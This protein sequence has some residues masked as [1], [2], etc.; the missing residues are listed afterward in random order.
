[1]KSPRAI[2]A[3]NS[4]S[5]CASVSE[6]GPRLAASSLPAMSSACV[7]IDAPFDPVRDGRA[8]LRSTIEDALGLAHRTLQ[9]HRQGQPDLAR[10]ADVGLDVVLQ[11]GCGGMPGFLTAAREIAA[12][13]H[14]NRQLVEMAGPRDFERVVGLELRLL[15]D[16]LLHLRRKQVDAAD[17]QHVVRAAGDLLDPPHAARG[18]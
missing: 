4:A 6:R 2:L 3:S 8:L 1:M 7:Y 13:L 10:H 15:E 17:D 16:Q 9:F 12:H 14:M 18:R 5:Y 11:P